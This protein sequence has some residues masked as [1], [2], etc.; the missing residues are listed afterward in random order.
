MKGTTGLGNW[1]EI[2]TAYE[3]ARMGT[4]SGAAEALGIHHATVIRHVDALEGRLGVKLFQRHSRGYSPTDAGRELFQVAQGASDS[5]EQ[6]A[7]RI[8]SH[9]ETV[10]GELIVTAI[11]G[12]PTLLVP[13]IASFQE[14][15]PRLTIRFLS[16]MRLF[17]LNS[18][19]A[20]VA[21]RAGARPEEPDFVVQKFVQL[22]FALYAA[23]SYVERFGLPRSE[24]DLALHRFVGSDDPQ[25]RPPFYVWLR[26]AVPAEVVRFRTSEVAAAEAA[27]RAG[28]GIGF[29]G[30]H[31]ARDDPTL[32][33]ILPPRP[34][35][36]I[37]LWLVTHVDLHRSAK[38]QAFIA[39]IKKAAS[40]W[41]LA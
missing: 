17:R 2:R 11:S 41:T 8:R 33:E 6:L 13:A 34:D 4:V 26:A 40:D 15:Y 31:E 21:I 10:S 37:P 32:V 9:S 19:E 29:I 24:A 1:D 7:S 25:A 16:D 20:H 30:L 36:A 3:V 12:L 27:V 5:F 23:R 38:V 14:L 18:G 28:A 39:H 22:P 35:W